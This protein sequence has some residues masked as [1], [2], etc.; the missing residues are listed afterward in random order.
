M[1]TSQSSHHN[2]LKI[3]TFFSKNDFEMVSRIV[4]VDCDDC[5]VLFIFRKV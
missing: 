2:T 5:D 1:G 4:C 3:E